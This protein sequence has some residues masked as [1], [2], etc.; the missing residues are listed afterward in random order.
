MQSVIFGFK[1]SKLEVNT[2]NN[3]SIM[4]PVVLDK[5]LSCQGN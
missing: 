3:S 1:S 4:D 5:L 2:L